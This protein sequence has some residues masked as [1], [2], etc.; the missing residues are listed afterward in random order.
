MKLG[1]GK[2]VGH[3]LRRGSVKISLFRGR[4][5]AF[6]SRTDIVAAEVDHQVPSVC[7]GCREVLMG[8]DYSSR[9]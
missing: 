1:A 4:L 6:C 2:G 7:G 5:L 8:G 3:L 9:G